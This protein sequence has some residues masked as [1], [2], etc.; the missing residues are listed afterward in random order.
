M[1]LILY[2]RSKKK[3]KIEKMKGVIFRIRKIL[4]MRIN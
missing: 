2:I 4:S 1:T 3:V